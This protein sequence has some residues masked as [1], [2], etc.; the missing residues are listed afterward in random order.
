L[1]EAYAEAVYE[2]CVV[3]CFTVISTLFNWYAMKKGAMVVGEDRKTLGR[4]MRAMPK[5]IASFVTAPPLFLWRQVRRAA[6]A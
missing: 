3:V 6:N 5:I 1:V 2:H 4:D